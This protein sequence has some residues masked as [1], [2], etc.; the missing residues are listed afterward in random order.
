M[1]IPDLGHLS[2][3]TTPD[4][5]IDLQ[6]CNGRFEVESWMSPAHKHWDKVVL[7]AGHELIK[8]NLKRNWHFRGDMGFEVKLSE[9]QMDFEPF[10]S[11][12]TA[13]DDFQ[14]Q[15]SANLL[16]RQD[17]VAY[18]ITMWFEAPKIRVETME[19]REL[20]EPDGFVETPP[21][22]GDDIVE[23]E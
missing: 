22:S 23:V 8:A 10:G 4:K 13:T 19:N 12:S 3:H 6:P 2:I 17:K 14:A 16:Q 7:E 9:L 15:D 21:A 11:I 20:R 5:E 18:V 1:V